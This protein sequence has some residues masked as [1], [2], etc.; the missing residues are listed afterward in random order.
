[1][2]KNGQTVFETAPHCRPV[3]TVR[4]RYTPTSASGLQDT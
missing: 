2:D 1:M 4:T 3:T